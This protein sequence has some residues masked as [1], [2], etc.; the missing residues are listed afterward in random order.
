MCLLCHLELGVVFLHYLT[1][2]PS[3][4]VHIRVAGYQL[5]G[6]YQREVATEKKKQIGWWSNP[7]FREIL[8]FRVMTRAG[9]TN[10]GEHARPE[11]QSLMFGRPVKCRKYIGIILGD[12]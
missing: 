4:P 11:I 3:Y 10:A 9:V 6:P 5:Q 2:R 12:T 8:T 1:L 7:N